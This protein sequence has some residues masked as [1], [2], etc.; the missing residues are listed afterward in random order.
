MR[1]TFIYGG[2]ENLGVEYLSAVLKKNGHDVYLVYS[3]KLFNDT[4]LEIEILGNFFARYDL[5]AK[6]IVDS[7]PDLVCFSVVTDDY[8]WALKIARRFKRL[9]PNIP[10]MFGGIHPTSVPELVIK[11]EEVDYVCVGEGEEA[12]LDFVETMEQG[13]D[14]SKVA[15]IWGKHKNSIFR[16]DVRPLIKDLD[17]IP[18]PDK[19]L[20]YN[21]A[22]Y[23]AYSYTT[24][25]S[26]GCTLNCPY[27]HHN[28]ERKIYSGKGKYFRRRSVDNIISELK[29]AKEY[30]NIKRVM[31]EDDMVLEDKEWIL[32]FANK[33]KK[34]IN[35]PFMM[36]GHP[37][38]V[39]EELAEALSKAGCKYIEIGVQT[40]N[41]L[42]KRDILKR[43]ENNKDVIK[44]LLILKKYGIKFNVDQLAGL[45]CDREEDL[46][47]SAKVYNFLRP[48]RIY[49]LFLT[50]YP[51]TEMCDI[52]KNLGYA[53]D[54]EIKKVLLGYGESTVQR[55]SVTREIFS[56]FR[57]LYGFLPLLPPW[58]VDILI[59]KKWY[60]WLPKYI[61]LCTNVP[62]SI[63][64]LFFKN[65]E[66]FRGPLIIWKYVY[67]LLRFGY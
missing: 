5:L 51:K 43:P 27:C 10:V 61:P 11:N 41:Q 31:F 3:P 9:K 2:F 36:I 54:D 57:F 21:K 30:F 34:E 52:V 39:D 22:P 8:V 58:I 25:V 53:T 40:F 50:Y 33:Y 18:F 60:K 38:Q 7:D 56:E 6:E 16:N 45:P 37:T 1:I 32:E 12:L 13:K 67:H 20:F 55:G 63:G 24:M 48:N 47:Y 65:I 4:M 49:F 15:N 42:V 19:E 62:D 35:V 28:V 64:A 14:V 59:R 26:R 17:G 44:H 29:Y 23:H 46:I 66:D